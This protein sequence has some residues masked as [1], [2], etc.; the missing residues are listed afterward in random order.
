MVRQRFRE[1]AES[2]AAQLKRTFN[3]EAIDSLRLE[4]DQPYIGGLMAFFKNRSHKRS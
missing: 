2:R 3:A 1:I 4:T